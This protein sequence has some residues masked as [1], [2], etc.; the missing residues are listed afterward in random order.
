M[1][2]THAVAGGPAT[3][4]DDP[5]ARYDRQLICALLG[6]ADDAATVAQAEA[7]QG[8]RREP[9]LPSEVV[10]VPGGVV[11]AAAH[12]AAPRDIE[13]LR[14]A[15]AGQRQ[16]RQ[17]LSGRS[18]LYLIGACNV[19]ACTLG[20]WQPADL[21]ALLARAGVHA[22]AL[23][24]IVGDG[25]GRDPGRDDAAQVHADAV[26]FASLL[27]GALRHGHGIATAVHAR[28][29]AVRV[30]MQPLSTG[31][32][33][34]DAGRKLTAS[35]ADGVVSEHHAPQSKLRLWWDGERQ[36]RAWSY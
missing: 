28:V 26:S 3:A 9:P 11:Q 18:R 14:L 1:T 17:P 24:S 29:G 21:A 6:G 33:T 25:A 2:P 35:Q 27:H 16:V 34:I 32:A 15:V 5:E 7:L 4:A 20:G 36:M 30:L 23:I 22:L 12:A 8:K 31:V 19:A 13:D 10:A